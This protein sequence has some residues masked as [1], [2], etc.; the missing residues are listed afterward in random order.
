MS[1]LIAKYQNG[2]YIVRLYDD[3]TKIRMNDLDNLTPAFAESMDVSIT[4]VCN[5][6][7]QY[8]Y[9]N[10][11]EHGIH[12]DLNQPIFDT[13][14]AGT[15]MAINGNDLTHP[16]LENFLIRMKNK[17]VI[18]NITVNQKHFV[19]NINKLKEWQDR[20]L[21]WGIGVSLTN[22]ADPTLVPNINKLKNV[23]LHVI[24]GLFTKQ[25]MENLKNKNLKLL[26]LGYKIVGRG[27]EYYN[28][29]KD[30]IEA[31][32]AYLRENLYKNKNY[33][34]GCGFDTLSTEHLDLRK[35][36]GEDIWKT[37]FMGAEGAFTYYID[38]CNK[39]FAISSM[40]TE[41]IFPIKDGDTIDTMFKH[42]RKVAGH[43]K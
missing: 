14:H 21:I 15:E 19:P 16:D 31:N 23:V 4:T 40:E 43:D 9:L 11:T 25:D 3:G 37:H 41:N 20:Q 35:Q 17:G 22:S 7:C 38:A 26:V 34:A 6:K 33:F 1:K 42:I 10:C 12:A 30:E 24:D 36:V 29:H 28:Q 13:V 18:V 2:N 39:K 5:G 32:I 27:I 8:C